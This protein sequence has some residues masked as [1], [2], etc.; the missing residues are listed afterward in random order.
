MTDSRIDW[1]LCMT[2]ETLWSEFQGRR[3]PMQNTNT[4]LDGGRQLELEKL[5]TETPNFDFE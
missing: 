5:G 4:D 2:I 1:T 3:D